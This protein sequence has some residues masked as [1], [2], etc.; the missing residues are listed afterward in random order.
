MLGA[1]GLIVLAIG[2]LSFGDTPLETP[3]TVAGAIVLAIAHVGNL[4]LGRA[5]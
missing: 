4:K 5:T 2:V 1:A 3:L